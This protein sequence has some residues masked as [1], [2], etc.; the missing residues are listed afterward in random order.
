MK[1]KQYGVALITAL[2]ITAVATIAAVAMAARQQL[3]IRRA[4]NVIDVD[5]AYMFVLGVEDWAKQILARDRKDNQIDNLEEDWATILPPLSVEGGVVAGRIEDLQGLF[6]LNNLINNGTPS[7]NDRKIFER[8]LQN[9]GVSTD[10]IDAV[11]DW[12]DKDDQ[13]IFPHGAEDN[14]YLQRDI[15]YRTPNAAMA[16]P[17][18][19]LLVKGMSHE[20]YSKIAPYV[21]ALPERTTININTAPAQVL[22]AVIEGLTQSEAEQIVD[23]RSND[24]FSDI[25]EFMAHTL[26]Q[27]RPVMQDSIGM[28]SNY[29]MVTGSAQ[30]DQGQITLYSLLSR[31]D[32]AEVQV[33]MRAQ[34]VY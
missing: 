24:P 4:G 6:N 33:I 25:N 17:S 26:V 7:A 12:M 34:G 29:F 22:V 5:R 20:D 14:D 13:Q 1:Q 10:I 21:T 32:N 31:N 28:G 30:F 11:V 19:L 2:L 8:L 9:A 16:S 3:D 18:E 27:N 15:P 23:D